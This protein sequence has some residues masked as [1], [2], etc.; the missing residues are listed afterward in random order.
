MEKFKDY[1]L[2]ILMFIVFVANI[3]TIRGFIDGF[4]SNNKIEESKLMYIEKKLK[5]LVNSGYAENGFIVIFNDRENVNED[6]KF[7]DTKMITTT[8]VT[9]VRNFMIFDKGMDYMVV[10]RCFINNF[11]EDERTILEKDLGKK[12][13]RI[14]IRCPII[15]REETEIIGFYGISKYVNIF[16]VESTISNFNA[17]S[18]DIQEIIRK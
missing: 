1:L 14:F 3:N 16:D 9:H 6:E 15:L 13:T 12:M 7:A 4:F 2:I 10:N 17:I 11:V 18:N 5:D 8:G